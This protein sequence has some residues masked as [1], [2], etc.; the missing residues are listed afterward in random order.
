MPEDGKNMTKT[1]SIR[2]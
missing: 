1:N 2:Y